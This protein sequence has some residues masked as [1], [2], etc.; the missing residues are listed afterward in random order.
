VNREANRGKVEVH[1]SR[2]AP[3]WIKRMAEE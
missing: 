3:G 2:V 1:V